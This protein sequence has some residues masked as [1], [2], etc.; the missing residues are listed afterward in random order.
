[1]ALTATQKDRARQWMA[2]KAKDASVPVTWVKAAVNDTLDAI[3]TDMTAHK[4]TLSTAMNTASTPHGITWTAAQKK[5]LFALWSEITF[6]TD[7]DG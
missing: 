1:M 2:Q 5:I 7:K 3:D 4:A 6:N